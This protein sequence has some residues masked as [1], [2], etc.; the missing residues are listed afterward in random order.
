MEMRTTLLFELFRDALG[1]ASFP[2]EHLSLLNEDTLRALYAVSKGH[3][4]AQIV[5]DTLGKLHLLQGNEVSQKFLKQQMLAVYRYERMNAAYQKICAVL[6]QERIPYLPLKGSVIRT[7]YPE[8]YY[9]TSCDIDLLVKEE[10]LETAI[11]VLS[12]AIETEKEAERAYHDVSLYFKGGVHL[13]LHFSILENIPSMDG[14][15]SRVWEHVSPESEGL[16]R[17]KMTEEFFLFHQIAHAAYHFDKGGCGIRPFLDVFL[18]LQKTNHDEK[19]LTALLEEA[20]LSS[21][22]RHFVALARVWFLGEAHTAITAQMEQYLLGAGVYGSFENRVVTAAAE[23]RGS[24]LLKRIFPSFEN[25]KKTYPKLAKLPI[26]YPF[27]VIKRWFSIFNGKKRKRAVNEI[28]AS[29]ALTNEKKDDITALFDT[30]DL[31]KQER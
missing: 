19:I 17:Q 3:D 24:Y 2:Q 21:F 29:M 11:R 25:L 7:L 27:Y 23:S 4:L 16:S 13:E 28:K 10:H 18:I 14:V 1:T 31:R 30:L 20:R 9:R 8:P 15:L 6:E 5:A 22:Y 12:E 26:L